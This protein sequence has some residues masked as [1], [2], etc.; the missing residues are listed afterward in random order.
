MINK[1]LQN[2]LQGILEL[3]LQLPA[4]SRRHL[5]DKIELYDYC[6]E[7]YNKLLYIDAVTESMID[8]LECQIQ[9]VLN[10]KPVI[11]VDTTPSKSL[12]K[13]LINSVKVIFKGVK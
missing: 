9:C 8:A 6:V 13:D 2:N 11:E 3:E 7:K 5:D 4:F 10:P 1:V 12:V